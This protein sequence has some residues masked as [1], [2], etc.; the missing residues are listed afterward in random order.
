MKMLLAFEGKRKKK[1]AFYALEIPAQSFRAGKEPTVAGCTPNCH[2]LCLSTVPGPCQP[3]L[4]CS[5]VSSS[6]SVH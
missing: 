3:K 5:S 6:L 4:D 2:P 1:E